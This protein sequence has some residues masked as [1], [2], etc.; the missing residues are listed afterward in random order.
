MIEGKQEILVFGLGCFGRELLNN[1]AP[2]WHITAVDMNEKRIAQF[3]E[4]F[5]AATFLS[6]A[7][8]SLVTWKKLGLDGIKYIISTIKDEEV[9]AETCRIAREKFKLDAPFIILTY[10]E[11]DEKRFEPYNVT[12]VNALGPGIQSVRKIMEKGAALAVNLGLGRGELIEVE[13]KA[14]SH[15][16]GRKLKTLCPVRWHISAIY[17][18]G[19]MILPDGNSVLKVGDRVVLV[20]DPRVLENVT[21]TLLKGLPEFPR[22]YGSEIVLPLH[23]D[24]D[25]NMDEALY[26]LEYFKARR[27]HFIPFKKKLSHTCSEKI[28]SDVKAFYMGQAIG[29][30]KEIFMLSLDTGLLVVPMDKGWLKGYRVRETFKKSQKPFL[31]SRLSFPYEGVVV[32]LNGPDPVRTLETGIEVSKLLDIPYRVVYVTMPKEMRGRQ[33]DNELQLCRQT[34]SDFEGIYKR[35]I[36]YDTLEGNPVLKTLRFLEPLRNHLLVVATRAR[37]R[38]SIFKPSVSYLVAK[39]SRLST[40]VI[41]E[42]FP[43]D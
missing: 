24:F 14:R 21:A 15:L 39:K 37:V 10:G 30:F 43:N 18:K 13:I 41:P 23:D 12:M 11:I 6:G 19:E 29:L 36:P 7:A 25:C 20:G 16:V 26:W 34:V 22:Q 3:K 40:L 5:P 31:L 4:E 1:L 35:K 9:N 42:A 38:L 32:L 27:I 2:A 8:G 17:R 28:K 33:E